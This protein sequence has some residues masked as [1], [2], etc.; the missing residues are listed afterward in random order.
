M[1]L[2]FASFVAVYTFLEPRKRQALTDAVSNM[3]QQHTARIDT[4]LS[5]VA[6]AVPAVTAQAVSEATHRSATDRKQH[7]AAQAGQQGLAAA[8]EVQQE[9]LRQLESVQQQ[10]QVLAHAQQQQGQQPS[11]ARAGEEKQFRVLLVASG[12]VCC[13]H[14]GCSVGA[15]PASDRCI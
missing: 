9:V 7:L 8:A 2:H 5:H 14:A 6:D 12:S 11:L 10:L 4:M 13:V 3:L 15:M 1:G